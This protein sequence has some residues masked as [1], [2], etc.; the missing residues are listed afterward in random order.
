[1]NLA[2]YSRVNCSSNFFS[3]INDT[4]GNLLVN[5]LSILRFFKT[6]YINHSLKSDSH[7]PKNE[8]PV[9]MMKNAFNFTLKALFVLKIFKLF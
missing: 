1:M 8:S 4:M 9:K 7:P 5:M 6:P 2:E 3:E